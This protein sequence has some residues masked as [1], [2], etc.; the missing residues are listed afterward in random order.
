MN[1]LL[2]LTTVVLL[3][4]CSGLPSTRE[5]ILY[6]HAV[7][8]SAMTTSMDRVCGTPLAQN[9]AESLLLKAAVV[10]KYTTHAA[11]DTHEVTTVI[12]NEY[13][14]LAASYTKDVPPSVTYCKMKVNLIGQSVDLL[15]E[16]LG[17]KPHE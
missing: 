4:S 7:E 12:L 10:D 16:M 11:K 9:V 13:K 2:L 6:N 3:T 15:I 8:L 17:N 5:P 14:E 1:K